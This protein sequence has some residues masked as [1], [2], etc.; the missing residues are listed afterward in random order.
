MSFMFNPYPYD[1]LRPINAPKLSKDAVSG[2][3]DGTVNSFKH[4][5]QSIGCT[6]AKKGK[7][8]VAVEGYV[9]TDFKQLQN[10]IA[11]N[12]NFDYQLIDI[13]AYYKSSQQLNEMFDKNLPKDKE[14]DPV[15]LY[16]RLFKGGYE[17]IFDED[18]IKGLYNVLNAEKASQIIIVCG[19][20]SACKALYNYYDIIIYSDLTPKELSL[21]AKRGQV[22]N[23]G[24]IFARPFKE[25]MRRLYYV[26]IELSCDVR[27]YL[28]REEKID[29]Y[30]INDNPSKMKLVTKRALKEIFSALSKYPFRCKPVY[31]EGI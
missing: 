6:F 4:I 28:L 19:L 31:L 2:I 27:G 8:I 9:G 11:Q 25:L 17:N 3:I 29:Y 5:C 18:K 20:G 30:L 26:D 1:D 22:K 7:C 14:K 21:R 12:S 24:D 10:L 23:I 16:G 13:A 15:L